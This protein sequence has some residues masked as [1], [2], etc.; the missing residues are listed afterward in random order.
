[1]SILAEV[2]DSQTIQ[3]NQSRVFRSVHSVH[4]QRSFDIPTNLFWRP[5]HLST[6]TAV[7][8]C[9]FSY[10]ANSYFS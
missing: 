10:P 7:N 9:P 2:R 8:L 4:C 6:V 1:M 5:P 3:P